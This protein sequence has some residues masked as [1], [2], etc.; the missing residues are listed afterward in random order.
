[1]TE[2]REETR[3]VEE[4]AACPLI[5]GVCPVL[6]EQP[7]GAAVTGH[8]VGREEFF[9]RKMTVQALVEDLVRDP[10]AAPAEAI[11]DLVG[12]DVLSDRQRSIVI[13]CMNVQRS[14][15]VLNAVVGCAHRPRL[16]D[17]L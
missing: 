8:E 17:E 5:V 14:R 11:H 6:G 12:I 2:L 3:L 1:M 9:E 7:Q 10:E 15:P 4:L 13:A 16:A